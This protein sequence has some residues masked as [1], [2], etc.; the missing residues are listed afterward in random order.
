MQ[1][2]PR[3]LNNYR[4]LNIAFVLRFASTVLRFQSSLIFRDKFPR[5]LAFD[6][7]LRGCDSIELEFEIGIVH[8]SKFRPKSLQFSNN[9]YKLYYISYII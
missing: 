5:R 4:I 7:V 2:R 6:P 3:K 8:H 9:E 1:S